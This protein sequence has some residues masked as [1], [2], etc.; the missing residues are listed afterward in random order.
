MK[1]AEFISKI[2]SS[3]KEVFAIRDLEILFPREAKSIKV[4]VQRFKKRGII[5][6][7]ARGVYA[8]KDATFDIEK[9]AQALY[10]PSYTSFES[11]LS[12]YGIINQG[13]YTLT[14]ATT[15]KSKK[16]TLG[17]V[18]CVYSRLKP[19][20]F[21]GFKLLKKIYVADAEKAVCDQLY[22]ISKG[23]ASKESVSS[24]SA[25]E[26]NKKRLKVY[27]KKFPAA[28]QKAVDALV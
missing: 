27:S 19:E 24:W 16:I 22:M 21:F 25:T 3:G 11:A 8:L 9:V 1:Q 6:D 15:R 14:L 5:S 28:V 10:Y 23:N 26:L 7:L 20:L 12:R 13:P 4:Y 18:E 2:K 17:G